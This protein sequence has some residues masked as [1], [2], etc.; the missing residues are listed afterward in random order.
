MRELE[1][2][3][4]YR[5]LLEGKREFTGEHLDFQLTDPSESSPCE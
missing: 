4:I 3:G 2:G 1:D 5:V